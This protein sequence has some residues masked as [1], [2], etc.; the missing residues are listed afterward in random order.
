[1]GGIF[2][3]ALNCECTMD[4]FFGTDYHSHLGVSRGGLA[5]YNGKSFS[6]AIHKIQNS[7]FRS[8]FESDLPELVGNMGIGCISDLEPQPITVRSHHGHYA[9]TTVGRINNVEEIIKE[10]FK[11]GN[12]HFFEL[13]HGNVNQTELVAAIINSRENLLEGIQAA[14]NLIQGSCSLLLMTTEGI[15]AVRDRL[16]RTPLIIGKGENGHCVGT[17]TCSMSNIG[18]E[19][20]YELGPAEIVY[21]KPDAFEVVAPARKKK[22]ICAFLWTYYGYPSSTYE[23]RNV[24]SVR[25]KNGELMADYDDVPVDLVGGIPDSGIAH[26]I[27]YANRRKIPFA[28]PFVK[29]TPTWPRSFMPKNQEIRNLVAHMKLLPVSKL[30][31]DQRLLLCDDSIVRG[32]QLSETAAY[33]FDKGAKEVHVRSSCPPILHSCKF[34][35]FS[36]SASDMSLIARRVIR[37]IENTEH[38]VPEEYIDH[39]SQKHKRMTVEI[40]KTLKL[41]SL[42]FATLPDM[43]KA[44]DLPQCDICTYCWTGKEEL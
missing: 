31:R 7:Q 24:E 14:Q 32:T 21:I 13:S 1:M 26:A 23:G 8:K 6:H 33:L 12:T 11:K 15:Y 29:Y 9:L 41:S 3:I 42:L 44:I 5:V 36:S 40:G 28:R 27:G 10:L 38:T 16:G 19:E 20:T 17:E 39:S 2:G 4:L 35:N 30:I 22:Q 25:Y 43:I 18:Y 37:D 34:L